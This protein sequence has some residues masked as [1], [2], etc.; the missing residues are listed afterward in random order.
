MNDIENGDSYTI[1]N[2]ETANEQI[3]L[4]NKKLGNKNIIM[5]INNNNDNN[6]KD[7]NNFMNNNKVFPIEIEQKTIIEDNYKITPIYEQE[8]FE[9]GLVSNGFVRWRNRIF[10]GKAV[11]QL[12]QFKE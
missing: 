6:K 10:Y 5:N 4:I 8:E 12:W 7:Y 2:S 11:Q 9:S 3:L 1:V